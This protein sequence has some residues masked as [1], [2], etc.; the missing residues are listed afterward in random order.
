MA[1]RPDELL[2]PGFVRSTL[3]GGPTTA[4]AQLL[5]FHKR[6]ERVDANSHDYRSSATGD[7]KL[8]VLPETRVTIYSRDIGDTRSLLRRGH[9]LEGV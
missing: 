5:H 7:A 4:Q 9:A 2:R 8:F 1:Q 6:D 3:A